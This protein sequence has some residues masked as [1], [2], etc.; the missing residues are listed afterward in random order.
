MSIDTNFRLAI[1]GIL[2]GVAGVI[3]TYYQILGHKILWIALLVLGFTSAIFYLYRVRKKIEEYKKYKETAETFGERWRLVDGQLVIG[4]T[5][6]VALRAKTVQGLLDEFQRAFPEHYNVIVR[7]AGR[8]VGESFADDLKK[9]LILRGFE[10]VTKPGRDTELLK[11]KLSLWA[12]Y[13]SS[14][15]MGIFEVYQVEFTV[16]GLRGNI[17]LKNSFLAYE[18][19]SQLPTCIFIEGYLEGVISKLLS[20]PIIAKEIECSS[21]TGSEYCK[22][23]I[24]KK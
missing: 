18:R 23:E 1:A 10:T 6:N 5:V 16:N 19:Q 2:L 14:T 17:L 21:V 3:G 24:T 20:I 8:I 13:D 22:F 12:E 11:K 4:N 9:E 15:G 7:N